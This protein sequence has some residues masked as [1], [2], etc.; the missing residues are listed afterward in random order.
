[1]TK[2]T[3]YWKNKHAASEKNSPFKVSDEALV[4]AQ[5]RLD[6][7][8]LSWDATKPAW[9]A[10]ASE[11]AESTGVKGLEGMAKDAIGKGI[12]KK[13]PKVADFLKKVEA[14]G[15]IE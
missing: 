1:M 13:A 9:T 15:S 12:K 6:K 14:R 3:A 11:V 7:K 10:A 4:K 2:N 8:E 5:K